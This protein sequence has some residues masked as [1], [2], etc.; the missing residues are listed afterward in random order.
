MGQEYQ[1]SLYHLLDTIKILSA[2]LGL[3]NIMLTVPT[4]FQWHGCTAIDN[5]NSVAEIKLA[6]VRHGQKFDRLE[7]FHNTFINIY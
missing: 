7:R 1:V 5:F 2:S 4:A 6:D 3:N